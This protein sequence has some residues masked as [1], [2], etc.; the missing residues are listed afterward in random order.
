MKPPTQAST[1][2][3]DVN[4][5]L[6]KMD[7]LHKS[8]RDFMNALLSTMLALPGK[9]NF[10]N[11][12]RFG[13]YSEKSYARHF[14]RA[15][16]FLQFNQLLLQ[17][18]LGDEVIAAIDTSFVAKSGKKTFGL[19]RFFDTKIR[20]A[21]RGLEVSVL[22][23][24][25]VTTRNAYTLSA[26]QTP[27]FPRSKTAPPKSERR[28]THYTNQLAHIPSNIRYL[29]ADGAYARKEFFEA[30]RSN[31]RHL[32]TRLRC[33]ANLRHLFQGPWPRRKGRKKRYDGKVDLSD[34]GRMDF[35]GVIDED[36]ELYTALVNSPHMKQDFR[37]AYLLNRRKP[38]QYIDLASTDLQLDA[39]TIVKY[40][41]LRFQIEMIFRDSKQHTGL[42]DAQARSQAKLDFHFNAALSA[43]NVARLNWYE[44]ER[45][46]FSMASIKRISFN[47][48][49]MDQIFLQLGLESELLKTHPAFE[50]LRSF[51]AIAA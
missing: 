33:D 42:C 4:D 10:R 30:V 17:G 5:I 43:L 9:M 51:G 25:D 18:R 32:I 36:V 50:R 48:L 20:K 29:A 21:R 11:L 26:R 37:I 14:A 31:Q 27:A 2:M 41:S 1:P 46:T 23:L 3:T 40:Y 28:L 24:V 19:D 7:G 44:K 8:R 39:R 15:F 12:G 34:V 47:E 38:E 13:S 22:A 45:N 35:V 49:F 16:D 6:A